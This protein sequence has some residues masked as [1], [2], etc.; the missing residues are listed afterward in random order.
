M[1][2]RVSIDQVWQQRERFVAGLTA[3]ERQ[4]F[5][6]FQVE[7]RKR[8]WLAG[9]VAAKRALQQKSGLPFQALEIRNE[10]GGRPV[11][12]CWHLSITHSGDAAGAVV[13][14]T[15]VGLDM[16]VIE[17]RDSSFVRLVF[18]TEERRQLESIREPDAAMTR[19]WCE[20]EAYAKALGHGLRIPF[21]QLQ[22]PPST[23]VRSGEFEHR[24]VRYAWAC[25]EQALLKKMKQP[26][27]HCGHK[28]C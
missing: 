5:S 4:T 13:S 24:G 12:S 21:S 28:S 7:K 16:E 20:K 25:V 8:D 19:L 9:R 17:P 15:P 2:V 6:A 14:Q 23:G 22:L 10:P 27:R 11:H 3:L 26:G 1:I 18:S